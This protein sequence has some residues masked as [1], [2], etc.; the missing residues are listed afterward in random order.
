MKHTISID[1][2]FYLVLFLV[3]HADCGLAAEHKTGA[4]RPEYF[5]KIVVAPDKIVVTDEHHATNEFLIKPDR[6]IELRQTGADGK[7]AGTC[8]SEMVY[9]SIGE[10]MEEQ[11][12][13]LEWA[14]ESASFKLKRSCYEPACTPS[15]ENECI[16]KIEKVW[17]R[18]ES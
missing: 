13:L 15:Q 12:E 3:V 9:A 6:T 2:I 5:D 17:T 1:G 7:E 16:L 11:L 18:P 4:C 14:G 8:N 10:E